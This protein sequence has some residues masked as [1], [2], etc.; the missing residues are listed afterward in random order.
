M[1]ELTDI[2]TKSKKKKNQHTKLEQYK[3]Q[4]CFNLDLLHK[5]FCIERAW[6]EDVPFQ[7]FV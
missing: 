2:Y 4:F 5:S 3:I 7:L 6:V 1:N